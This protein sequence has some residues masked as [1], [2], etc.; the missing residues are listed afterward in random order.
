MWQALPRL[1]GQSRERRDRDQPL[2]GRGSHLGCPPRQPGG[3][4]PQQLCPSA[5]PRSPPPRAPPSPHRLTPG[6]SCTRVSAGLSPAWGVC[7]P[8]KPHPPACRAGADLSE[9]RLCPSPPQPCRAGSSPSRPPSSLLPQGRRH[10]ECSRASWPVPRPQ[11]PQEH[12]T[13]VT[14]G[15][16]RGKQAGLRPLRTPQTHGGSRL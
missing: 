3:D 1:W 14:R 9:R 12:E 6:S 16:G 13:T 5:C 15:E 7:T 2:P 10:E 4:P 8:R 11:T